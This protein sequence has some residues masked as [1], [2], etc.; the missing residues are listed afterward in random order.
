[1]TTLG[2]SRPS[3]RRCWGRWGQLASARVTLVL[4]LVGAL[5][6][7]PLDRGTVRSASAADVSTATRQAPDAGRSTDLQRLLVEHVYLTGFL[8]RTILDGRQDQLQASVDAADVNT[9]ALADRVEQTRGPEVREALLTAWR[10]QI[11]LYIDYAFGAVSNDDA[12]KGAA[13]ASLNDARGNIDAAV[14]GDDSGLSPG[15]VAE[16][17]RPQVRQIVG[18]VDAWAVGDTAGGY[19]LLQE[20]ASGVTALADA[21]AGIVALGA[22]DA[23]AAVARPAPASPST[24]VVAPQQ[25]PGR[26]CAVARPAA[27]IVTTMDDFGWGG[28]SFLKQYDAG[29]WGGQGTL[30]GFER[31]DGDAF[32]NSPWGGYV[33]AGAVVVSDER[34]AATGLSGSVDGWTGDWQPYEARS[35]P[36]LGDEARA[37]VRLTP[38]EI[39]Q[40]QPMAEV[41]LA[42]RQCNALVHV[43]LAVMPEYGPLVQAERYARL[44][45]DRL[46]P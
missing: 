5:L 31:G 2:C 12:K 36:G 44:M 33:I 40:D 13:L 22:P 11:G 7:V 30:V 15:V 24:P 26:G 43:L 18:A 28:G 21:L 38:W 34:E 25:Q 45:L 6:A 8:V 29:Y 23:P 1:M 16:L 27:R 14:T 41:F 37:V 20:A 17:L 42:A 39:A 4:A 32:Q 35:L 46:A 19:A 3:V 9:R 10:A